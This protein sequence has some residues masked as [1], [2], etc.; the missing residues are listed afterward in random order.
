MFRAIA[1]RINAATVVAVLALVLA[2]TGG[3]YAAKRYLITSTKQVSPSVLKA[4]RGKPGVQGAAGPQGAAGSQ[5]AAG[6]AGAK[7]ETGSAGKEGPAGKEGSAGKEGPEGAEG[8]EGKE[9]SP[10]PAGGT[11]PAGQTETGTFVMSS[12]TGTGAYVHSVVGSISFAIPLSA[13]LDKD[14]V[15]YVEPESKSIPSECENS[16]HPGDASGE[17]PEASA[18]YLCVYQSFGPGVNKTAMEIFNSGNFSYGAS[19][20]GATLL[21]EVEES[22]AMSTGTWAVTAPSAS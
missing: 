13:P 20:S 14:H 12:E 11:L 10:W 22:E 6:P 9:G 2:M 7:G 16:A 19:V 21:Q 3:A 18:G 15:V 8:P 1:A 17:N 4:L 5:G